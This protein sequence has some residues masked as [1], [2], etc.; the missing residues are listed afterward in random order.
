MQF[1]KLKNLKYLSLKGCRKFQNCVPYLSLS[2][3]FGFVALEVLDLRDSNIQDS[4]LHCFNA[5][6]K[7]RE[8]YLEEISTPGES[9]DEED[10]D[11]NST[12]SSTP[13]FLIRS[14]SVQLGNLLANR[15]LSS[16]NGSSSSNDAPGPSAPSPSS[17]S[18][19]ENFERRDILNFNGQQIERHT[20][21]N[22]G[23]A[24]NVAT[25]VIRANVHGNGNASSNP[26]PPEIPAHVLENPIVFPRQENN[27]QGVG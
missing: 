7:L 9:D 19:P 8:L 15:P 2:C 3:K 18:A 11:S 21:V 13:S 23:A 10:Y 4:E 17:S 14:G 27:G 24:N 22:T 1:S 6:S 25:I 12:P 20:I 26:D 5:L 16:S